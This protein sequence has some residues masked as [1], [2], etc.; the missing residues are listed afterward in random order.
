MHKGLGRMHLSQNLALE[1]GP[2]DLNDTLTMEGIYRLLACPRAIGR[3]VEEE[4]KNWF[5]QNICKV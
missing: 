2:R 1:I 4:F 3:W 5:E